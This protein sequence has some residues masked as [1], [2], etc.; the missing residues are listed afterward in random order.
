MSGTHIAVRLQMPHL[1]RVALPLLLASGCSLALKDL[2][3]S[4][5]PT[6]APDCTSDSSAP[7]ADYV[8]SVVPVAVG[9][10]LAVYI[11]MDNCYGR[12]HC[13]ELGE[14]CNCVPSSA[15][16]IGLLSIAATAAL[17]ASGRHGSRALARCK[18]ARRAHVEWISA[19]RP[20][21][22]ATVEEQME[23]RRIH[24]ERQ[25]KQHIRAECGQWREQ[26]AQAKT[27]EDKLKLARRKPASCPESVPA[28]PSR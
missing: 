28:E 5:T 18:R 26:L 22:F 16:A 17:I 25:R 8:A 14:S 12:D 27:N 13:G 7:S 20:A 10:P 3:S 2:P 24:A 19:G 21:D 23:E 9:L 11:G 4:Y 15:I 1:S 6:Q